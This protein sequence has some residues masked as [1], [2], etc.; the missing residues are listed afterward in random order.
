M[1]KIKIFVFF[2]V[3]LIVSFSIFAEKSFVDEKAEKWL[4]KAYENRKDLSS[5][6]YLSTFNSLWD[7]CDINE[8]IPILDKIIS[9]KDTTPLALSM[10]KNLKRYMLVLKGDYEKAGTLIK[11][12]SFILDYLVL[13]PFPN[14]NK[15]GFEE[16]YEPEKNLDFNKVYEG[17]DK[18]EIAFRKL[19]RRK[20]FSNLILDDFIDPSENSVAYLVS[21]INSEISQDC[22]LRGSFSGAFKI[23]L[24]SEEIGSSSNYNNPSFDQYSFPI[25][26]S[27]GFNILMIK[28]CNAQGAWQLRVRVTDPKGFPVKNIYTTNDLKK[29]S[30]SIGSIMKKNGKAS[31]QFKFVDPK[32]ELE[33]NAQNGGMKENFEYGL[34]LYGTKPFDKS[35][36]KDLAVFSSILEK[37]SSLFYVNYFAAKCEDDFNRRRDYYEK[38]VQD[39]DYKV[40]SLF[41]LYSYYFNRSMSLKAV[42]YINKALEIKPND[43]ILNSEK[44]Y[45]YSLSSILG[46]L[47]EKEIEE[48]YNLNKGNANVLRVMF[49]LWDERGFEEKGKIFKE[50]QKI[51]SD[52]FIVYKLF[53]LYSESGRKEEAIG[54]IKNY[55]NEFQYDR[56]LIKELCS[57]EIKLGICD[58]VEKILSD[59]LKY[60]PDWAKGREMLGEA[61]LQCGRNDEAL[62]EFEKSLLLN[63]Q[64]DNLKRRLSYLK[65]EEDLFYSSYKIQES[66]ISKG[67]DEYKDQSLQ[68]LLDN[69]FVLVEKSGLSSRYCQFAAKIQ[70]PYGAQIMSGFPITYD[71]DW[72]EV[73]VIEASAKREDGSTLRADSYTTSFLSDPQYQLYYR[74]RQLVLTFSGLKKGDTVFIEY[75]ITDKSEANAYGNYFG[76]FVPFQNIYPVLNKIYTL[77]VPENL[78]ITY[79]DVGLDIEPIVVKTAGYSIYQWSKKDIPQLKNEAYAPGFSEISPY[80]H[81]STFNS[82]E[83]LGKWYSSF[84][85]DQWELSETAK[86]LVHQ[87]AQG[88]TGTVDKV[89]E[90][91][92]WVLSNTR[93]VGL[94][95][96]VHGYKPYKAS[97]VFER[98]FGD[99]KDKALLLCA[100]LKEVNVDADMALLRTRNLGRIEKNPASLSSFN[101]AIAYIPELD[102]FLDATAEFSGIKEIPYL[103]QGVDALVVSSDGKAEV[104]TIPLNSSE[105]NV[106]YAKYNFDLKKGDPQVEVEGSYFIKGV[107]ASMIRADFQNPEKRKETLEKQLSRNYPASKVEEVGFSDITDTNKDI[108]I[109]FKGKMN[110]VLK[111]IGNSTYSGSLW[112]GNTSLSS[113]YCALSERKFAIEIPYA[114]KQVYDVTYKIQQGA[115]VSVPE[116]KEI[117]SKFG[118]F[119]RIVKRENNLV[120]V[121]SEVSLKVTR[122]EVDDYREFKSF[123]GEVDKMTSERIQIKW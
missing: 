9:S 16:Q 34:Y 13:A 32:S 40:E 19:P 49:Y 48:I 57:Y 78:K 98:R 6:S 102:L 23:F 117:V 81:I 71:P 85:K 73:R 84:I 4:Q 77:K 62:K 114:L 72:Q 20:N 83:D 91:Q 5:L 112:L 1:K 80:L 96:G 36:H 116:E 123:L 115:S 58:D 69:T 37:D 61:L 12:D 104:K 63:P 39:K 113:T 111:I 74:N 60:A 66:E 95:F 43:P 51:R 108:N 22:V 41:E 2:C 94:E 65:P 103:D 86:K 45:F 15:S 54:V 14:D 10:A 26:L 42:E 67:K 31:A 110:G 118:T 109:T 44:Y 28:T 7:N 87:I 89:I 25:K 97:Q 29:V 64:N 55:L 93:Y 18:R 119:K 107:E 50:Y 38:A 101:H 75:L 35:E 46:N 92:K 59:Y 8:A 56:D 106:F 70:S 47:A 120:N 11:E 122:V 68:I 88:K 82:W 3:A 21:F 33:K 24:N 53:Y 105:E 99:C 30:E 27:Q 76:D 17:T 90:I 52:R 79:N 100:M 121:V